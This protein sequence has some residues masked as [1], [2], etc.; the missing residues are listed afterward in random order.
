MTLSSMRVFGIGA[1]VMWGVISGG[2]PLWSYA[3][4]YYL[5]RL[6]GSHCELV[7]RATSAGR[8]H[9][10]TE[11]GVFR[12]GVELWPHPAVYG[13]VETSPR[14]ARVETLLIVEKNMSM[15]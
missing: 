8:L 15:K 1:G 13:L 11:D 7:M 10:E 9:A 5:L 6:E 3:V 4:N 2:R 12:L 14:S